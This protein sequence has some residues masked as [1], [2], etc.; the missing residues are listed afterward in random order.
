MDFVLTPQ[1]NPFNTAID[2]FKLIRQVDFFLKKVNSQ[3]QTQKINIGRS[4]STYVPN[5]SDPLIVAFEQMVQR[6]IKIVESKWI[7]YWSNMQ[8]EERQASK[9]LAD[10]PGIVIKEANKG[11]GVVILDKKDYVSEVKRQITDE[12]FYREVQ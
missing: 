12:E 5:M 8:K 11:G 6:K 7:P 1:Y 4:R 9:V 10:D 3:H 2:V